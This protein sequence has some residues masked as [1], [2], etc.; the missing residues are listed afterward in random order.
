[1]E[2]TLLLVPHPQK[3]YYRQS[4]YK[5][6]AHKYIYISNGLLHLGRLAQEIFHESGNHQWKLTS[7]PGMPQ[8]E[9]GMTITVNPL[10]LQPQ[11]YQLT[12]YNK[13]IEI[14]A[15]DQAGVFY[16]LM[17]LKQILRQA[18]HQA[19]PCLMILDWPD[20]I[21]RGVMLDISRDKVP[22]MPTLLKMVD[23]LSELKI[24]QFQLYTEHTFAYYD[25]EAIW[26]DSS[27]MTG[28]EI[29]LLDQYCQKKYIELVPNQNS[30]G[31]LHN[32]LNH[33]NYTDLAESND[34]FEHP[35]MGTKVMS[36]FS[37]C[38]LEPKALDF[39]AGLYK[40][41]LP[42]FS[43]QQFN[44]GCDETFDLGQGRSKQ[45]CEERGLGRVYLDFLQNIHTLVCHHGRTM[46]FWG[47]I[48]LNHPN[49]IS[50]V[51]RPCIALNW[52]YESD[53]PYEQECAVFEEAGIPFYVCP[54]TSSWNTI[55]GRTDNAILNLRNA[56]LQGLKHGAQGYL[57]TDWGDNGHWQ[58]LPVSYLGYTYGAGLAWA[59]QSNLKMPIKETLNK[60]VFQDIAGVLGPLA[61]D[62]G[63]AYQIPGVLIPNRSFLFHLLQV[64][65]LELSKGMPS[66]LS[67]NK[68]KK[69][70]TWINKTIKTLEDQQSRLT[71]G[72]LIQEEFELAAS[73]LTHACRMAIVRLQ[74]DVGQIPELIPD[75]RRSL[76]DEWQG[77]MKSYRFIWLQRNRPGGLQQSLSRFFPL[78]QEY[79]TT[80]T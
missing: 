71:D 67:L 72:T 5:I 53:H 16:A 28:E 68:M 64:P 60:H 32:W 23:L 79:E 1:M 29:L 13:L 3:L 26:Q 15:Q 33:P 69:T 2:E 14:E 37:L 55:A 74:T 4:A 63:N 73:L 58:P 75:I 59:V 38:P 43:S 8:K 7:N 10:L 77:L 45:A 27:P 48:I 66:G 41:L 65:Q 70:K 22:T 25:H 52:G 80:A 11:G 21:H 54:G 30:F 31:H 19:L 36:A 35:M 20:F 78:L 42:H 57:I 34:G 46:Q 61:Y 56:A 44:V 9:L 49:L 47:D 6:K 39:L 18:N 40:E 76:A 51:P 50:E 62:L 24:N 17:T 12:I